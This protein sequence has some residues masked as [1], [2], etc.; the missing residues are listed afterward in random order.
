MT[1]RN[2]QYGLKGLETPVRLSLTKPVRPYS[3]RE[4]CAYDKLRANGK[5]P[6]MRVAE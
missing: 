2:S 4:G 6:K 1:T 5:Y 3:L